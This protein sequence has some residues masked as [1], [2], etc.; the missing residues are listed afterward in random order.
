MRLERGVTGDSPR[1]AADMA[2]RRANGKIGKPRDALI[3]GAPSFIGIFWP[4]TSRP[5]VFNPNFRANTWAVYNYPVLA[6]VMQGKNSQNLSAGQGKDEDANT[7]RW[8]G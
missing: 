7:T 5:K 2:E 3:D 4:E 6:Q 1:Q 8:H